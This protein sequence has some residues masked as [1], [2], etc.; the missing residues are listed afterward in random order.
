MS[1]LSRHKLYFLLIICVRFKPYNANFEPAN[2][3]KYFKH[4]LVFVGIWSGGGMCV[5]K[6]LK[7]FKV[8]SL[9]RF[10]RKPCKR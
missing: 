1:P 6:R 3:N 8:R 5:L 9:G 2:T 10:W 4:V 7:H